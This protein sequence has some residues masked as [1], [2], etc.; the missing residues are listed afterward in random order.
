MKSRFTKSE[1]IFLTPNCFVFEYTTKLLSKCERVLTAFLFKALKTL[2][3]SALYTL[4]HLKTMPDNSDCP[5]LR[6][7][8]DGVCDCMHGEWMTTYK[9]ATK[10]DL[11]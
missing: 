9:I 5:Y 7:E 10:V 11:I 1:I 2:L 4:L 3:F 6:P 8:V